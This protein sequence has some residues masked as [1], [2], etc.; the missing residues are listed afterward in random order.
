VRAEVAG[1]RTNRRHRPGRAFEATA[2]TFEIVCDYGAYRDLQRH[3]MLTLQAQPLTP[4]LG[5]A[6]P[7]DVA[8]AGAEREYRAIQE[9][10][11]GLYADLREPFAHEAAYAVTLAH[12]IRFTMA[13][14]AREAMH[15]I[16]LRSQPQGHESYRAVA[17]RMHAAIRDE[18]G[19]RA[20]ADAM[21]FVDHS[22]PAAGRLEAERRSER[23]RAEIGST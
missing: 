14:N 1:E 10:C 11:A 16:E 21:I 5:Y 8:E 7:A 20:I 22:T 4:A 18:A 19:H 2:Y 6:V 3:R 15:L 12:R 13:M 23:R 17:Q 9:A